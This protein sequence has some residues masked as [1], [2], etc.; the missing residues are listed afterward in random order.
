MRILVADDDRVTRTILVRTLQG[1]HSDVVSAEDGEAAWTLLQD[2][3]PT[4][5][6]LDWMMPGLDGP[7]LCRRIRND[8]ASQ[9]VYVLLLSARDSRRDLVAGLEAGADDYLTKP[10][11]RDELRARVN[12]GVRV[13]ELQARLASQ[14]TELQEALSRV[15]QLQALLPICSY[16]KR[17]R[18]DQNYWEQIDTYIAQHSDTQF[19]HGICPS[20]MDRAMKDLEITEAD[21]R[22]VNAPKRS[23]FSRWR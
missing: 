21:V 22:K 11:D 6:I 13:L 7:A 14:V 1:W 9:R 3:H 19:S 8:A 4:I 16:C 5:A 23:R 17:I 10:F 15:R 20:C 12:V 18:S 2:Q